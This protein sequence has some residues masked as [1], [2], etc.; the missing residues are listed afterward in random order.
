MMNSNL[1]VALGT[2]DKVIPVVGLFRVIQ[3]ANTFATGDK[4]F[5]P[6]ECFSKTGELDSVIVAHSSS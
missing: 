6:S 1:E 3:N 4:T 2:Q 5:G